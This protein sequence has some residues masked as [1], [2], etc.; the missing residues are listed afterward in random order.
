LRERDG[1]SAQRRAGV[2]ALAEAN[3]EVPTLSR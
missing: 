3:A 1:T 2:D